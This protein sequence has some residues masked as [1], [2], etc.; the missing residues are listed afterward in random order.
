MDKKTSNIGI[1]AEYNPFHNGHLWQMEK[2][3]SISPS[4]S[5]I[6]IMSGNFMQ[7][8][9][10]AMLNKFRRA[11]VALR[12]GASIV[13]ELPAHCA[14]SGAECFARGAVGVLASLGIVDGI[15]FGV[16]TDDLNILQTVAEI[17]ATEQPKYKSTLKSVLGNGKGVGFA[18]ARAEAVKASLGDFSGKLDE[19]LRGPNNIL[20]LEYLSALYKF[21][22]YIKALPLKRQCVSHDSEEVAQNFASASFI[23]KAVRGGDIVNAVKY[24]PAPSVQL[25]CE[26]VAAGRIHPGI[27]Y[28]STII[29]YILFVEKFNPQNGVGR[30]IFDMS[31]ENMDIQ[32]A[33][34]SSMRR[35]GQI[36]EIIEEVSG[37]RYTR[38]KVRRSIMRR[39]LNLPPEN[40]A[41]YY[42]PAYARILGFRRR[43]AEVLSGIKQNAG[44][45]IITNLKHMDEVLGN[46]MIA[47]EMFGLDMYAEDIYNIGQIAGSG[48]MVIID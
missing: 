47:R 20:A 34:Y 13:L 38:A 46:N 31:S 25:L 40:Y 39:I 2:A 35:N 1:I 21:A 32:R 48:S 18:V 17:I 5:I 16:E 45:P 22:P 44:I 11:E 12:C 29:N 3:K 42:R 6:V 8:G 41:P 37:K 26:E 23:R 33:V 14:V 19:L 7:R 4:A 30:K 28:Y 9:E 36:S 24:M 15:C 43:D 27:D 10:P